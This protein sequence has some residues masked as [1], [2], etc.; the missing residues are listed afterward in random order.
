MQSESG[1]PPML[2]LRRESWLQRYL[3]FLRGD[4]PVAQAVSPQPAPR[5]RRE[6][7][8][9]CSLRVVPTVSP[10]RTHQEPLSLQLWQEG[11]K[12]ERIFAQ[13]RIQ[14]VAQRQDLGGS[15]KGLSPVKDKI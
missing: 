12:V 15:R 10:T 5:L 14:P 9:S 8:G 3:R 4:A 2:P 1:H 13:N 7:R 11:R 6:A